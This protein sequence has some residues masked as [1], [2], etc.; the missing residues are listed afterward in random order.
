LT[1]RTGLV[2]L[3]ATGF[4]GRLIAEELRRAGEAFTIAGRDPHRL[5][6]LAAGLDGL[7]EPRTVNVRD[8]RSLES[9]IHA[10]EV[11]INCVGPFSELG[12][13]VVRACIA[14]GAH[15][16]DITGEQPYMRAIADRHHEAASE[17]GVSV[18]PGMAFEYALGDCATAL[19]A[20]GLARPLRSIDVIYA[21]RGAVSSRGTRRTVVRMLGRRGEIVERG[22]RRRFAQGARWR[23]VVLSAGE[24]ARAVLFTSGE[25]ITVPRHVQASS[26]RGWA[27][28]GSGSARLIP[29]LSPLLPVIVTVLRPLIEFFATRRP[30]PDTAARLGSRFTIR[31]ELRDRT[32]LRR[33]IELR[34]RD[35]YGLTAAIAVAGARAA[36]VDGAPRGVVS[37]T[38]LVSPRPFLAG[39]GRLGLRVIENA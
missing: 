3:G 1:P 14:A 8:S 38:Q 23:E 24:P 21:W 6:E 9:G 4:T 11:V 16:L 7:A 17:A 33:A 34:G 5:D 15:Y 35:P 36:R 26:V 10:G 13:P 37:P 39:L 32:G 27:V 31:V 2:V 22:R 29:V 30:D 19:A 28:V 20:A 18:V 25:V 12:E